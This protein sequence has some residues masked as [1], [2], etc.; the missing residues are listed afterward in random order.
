M[1]VLTI[2]TDNFQ[3]E[4]LDA[5]QT[6]LIDFWASW[7]GPCGAMGPVVDEIAAENPDIKVGKINVDSEGDLAKQFHVMSIPT[8]A[9]FKNGKVVNRLVGVQLKEDIVALLK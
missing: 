8:L 5:Q 7:C 2:T 3:A 9:I 1:A 6:V 4:V